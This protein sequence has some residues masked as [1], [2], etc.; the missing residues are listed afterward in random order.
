MKHFSLNRG[1]AHY[2]DP[3]QQEEID[4]KVKHLKT[5]AKNRK[6]RKKRKRK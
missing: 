2:T 3:W 5:C 6:S 4:K 1:T